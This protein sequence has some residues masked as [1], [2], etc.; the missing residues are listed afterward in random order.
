MVVI[1]RNI[2]GDIEITIK[3]ISVVRRLFAFSI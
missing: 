1:C 3:F 2:K